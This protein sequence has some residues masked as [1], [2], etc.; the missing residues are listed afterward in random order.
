M[1][2]LFTILLLFSI[3]LSGFSQ[4]FPFP[5]NKTYQAGS[6]KPNNKTQTQLNT[7]VTNF[8]TQWK[9]R[10]FVNGCLSNQYYVFY[11]YEGMAGD[12]NAITVSEAH[13]YGMLI[14]AMMAGYDANAKIIFDGMYNYY[15]AHPSAIS[16]VLMSWQQGTGCVN[17]NGQDA[18]TDGDI[19]IAYALVMADK[20]WGSAGAVNYLQEAKNI[21]NGIM[22]YEINQSTWAPRLGDWA[23]S[24]SYANSTR[25]SDFIVNEFKSFQIASGNANWQKVVDKCYAL[26]NTIQ[27]NYSSTTGL[28][29]DFIMNVST[30]GAPASPFFLESDNDGNYYYNACR[31]PWRIGI[32]YLLTGDSRAL[33]ACTKLNSWIKTKTSST[34]ANIRAG[35][36]LSGADVAGNA[37]ASQ[38]FIS[39]FIVSAMVDATNQTWLNN[40]W[41]NAV[42]TS[43]SNEGYYENSIK[44]LCMIAGSGNWWD[45]T[46]T[47]VGA[48]TVAITTPVTN[49]TVCGPAS[50]TISANATDAD[51]T[52]SKVEFFNGTTLLATDITSPYS[53]VWSGVGSGTYSITAKATDNSAL[54]ATSSVVA[55]NVVAPIAN[56]GVDKAICIGQS[57]SLTASGGGTYLW[58][59]GSAAQV[60]NVSPF[61]TS[62]YSLT[63][64][65]SGCTAT[66]NIV[67][68]V[69]ANPTA[70]AGV[71]QNIC[72]GSSATLQASG[73][74][75]YL[76]NTGATS[77]F[78]TVTPATNTTYTVTVTQN[79]CT[80]TDNVIV[81]VSSK[82]VA[83]AGIDR[84]TCPGKSVAL[85]ATGGD[86][87]SWSNGATS[88]TITVSPSTNT[89]Y[90]VTAASA[91]GC[92]TASDMV[93]VNVTTQLIASAGADKAI[94]KGS[95]T[96][97]T[98]TGAEVYGWS[99]GA[100]TA[101]TLVAPT[102]STVY[103]V[104]A[105][106]AD[107]CLTA[108][109]NIIIT[110]NELP[111]A[112]AGAD[113]TVCSGTTVALTGSG[114]E[115]FLWSN[116]ASTAVISATPLSSA[117]YTLTV[118][119]ANLCS[120]Q[121]EVIITVN[122]TPVVSAGSDATS[123][124]GA[125]V[126][127]IA[128][129]ATS[130]L[131]S[132][133]PSD[134]VASLIIT[135]QSN[136]TYTV[137]GTSIEGCSASDDVVVST[138][139]GSNTTQWEFLTDQEGWTL[140][141][142]MVGTVNAGIL[143]VDMNVR[144]IPMYS[145]AGMCIDAT[146]YTDIAVK[147]KNS[148][149]AKTAQ[150]GWI[151][152]DFTAFSPNRTL[153]FAINSKDKV[154]TEYII[155]VS[156]NGG[157]AGTITQ[158]MLVPANKFTNGTIE[159]DYV[160]LIPAA[161]TS[162]SSS[163]NAVCSIHPNP[164]TSILYI[165]LDKMMLN[166]VNEIVINNALG[167]TVMSKAFEA[168]TSAIS[169][170][171]N[172]FESGMYFIT[173]KN[174]ISSETHKLVIE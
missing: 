43:L 69:N 40:L 65:T 27:T 32:D 104:T 98:A 150:I 108:T 23:T 164:A 167:Q 169:L 95:F 86:S 54:T 3:G 120:S 103:T 85:T 161:V 36:T 114:G 19:D 136:S 26:I 87:Y 162:V 105:S 2:K 99:T 146:Q 132:S 111:S 37:Y 173:I 148:S 59:N 74:A 45:P 119:D 20:Q 133:S 107:G 163:T 80:S 42:G 48:P 113:K 9:A 141:A 122:S 1:K 88:A 97:I 66:D 57:T 18:A 67:V 68:T 62:T 56:A 129:G 28:L 155:P 38:A 75:G 16:N 157:W 149:M 174:Q 6:I 106:T 139:S 24:G 76:W 91:S 12:P 34:P 158:L 78:I 116:G 145:P 172:S 73:G 47:T 160:K 30:G 22:Q 121:D 64:T 10:Y 110:V 100:T 29:P 21:I 83:N 128:S 52:I 35:Y 55:V 11:N 130:Y 17:I 144:D 53:Y 138:I 142:N 125:S 5:Q 89:T 79:A 41:A 126:K 101:S 109:D 13:G 135:P 50:I 82:I 94:C 96:T 166:N 31:D 4:Q 102:V 171:I 156:N 124:S 33:A 49:S 46:A 25:S 147:L 112:N 123:C 140:D 8:Y 118:T 70:N 137:T 93:V 72:Q 60:I 134:T 58:N 115:L 143:A 170:D 84:S 44:L 127:L 153:S 71:D 39:P 151:T 7:D 61:V 14:A 117:I 15:K 63:V 168:S 159:I 165:S 81:N 152:S 131:W 90:T 77:Q 154:F 51:G 92:G